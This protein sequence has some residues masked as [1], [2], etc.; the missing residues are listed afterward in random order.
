MIFNEKIECMGREEL[1]NLQ[2][3]RLK[4]LVAYIYDNNPVYR[5]K[6]DQH[7]IGPASVKSIDDI[8]NLPFTTK[9]DMRDNYPFKLFSRPVSEISEIHVSSGTTGNPTVVGYTKDDL[10]LWS[11]VVA[12]AIACAGG[13]PGDMIQIAYGYGLF[14]GGLGLHYGALKLGCTILPMSSGQTK[15][16][17]KLMTDFQ[18]RILC[19][20][21]SY[22]L[23]MLDE[24]R[25]MGLDPRASS[26]KIGIFG[27]EPWS[28]TMRTEIEQAWNML[29]T[30]IYGLSE[31]TGPG[32]SQECA[33]KCGMH[34]CSDVFYPEVID[35]VTGNAM[36]EGEYGELVF[37][38]LTKQGIP[39]LRY[40]TRDIVSINYEQC[41]C[42]RTSPRMSKVRGRTDD[43]II[44]RGIN[45]FPSQ[46]EHVLLGIE[47][48]QPHYQL[49]VERSVGG[50]DD[51]EIQV[52]IEEP[53]F[54]DEIKVLEN[55]KQ[56]IAREMESVLG[57]NAK[58]RFVEPKTIQRSEGKAKR[59]ID[60][61]TL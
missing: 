23:Y 45:V 56:K 54:S 6:L 37:T 3:E 46:I 33:H 14:T 20:T 19:C 60:K 4:K 26:W 38:T 36:P 48:V 5:K 50:L 24:A 25:E 17:L 29:A 32:V 59:V 30:D 31:I 28:D 43:M 47:G 39:L 9:E 16:Q 55:L 49:I 52:E 57:I 11:E 40:R 34:I 42:G 15:R 10:D 18:P 2:S 13:V 21:P 35:S 12:R 58:I 22:T 1:K 27:A 44:V 61:R 7:G 41:V 8:V 51:L 53:F